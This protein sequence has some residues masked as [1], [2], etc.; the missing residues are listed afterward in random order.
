VSVVLSRVTYLLFPSE[1]EDVQRSLPSGEHVIDREVCLEESDGSK[2]YI[3]WA[4]E[5]EQYCVG[6]K[7]SSWFIPSEIVEIDMSSHILWKSLVG[8]ALDVVW[9]DDKHQVLEIRADRSPVYLSSREADRWFA[10]TISVSGA[11]PALQSDAAMERS[12]DA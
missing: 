9:H 1:A 5:P 6:V 11:R 2:R 4:Q 10:D 3:S 7:L 8:S 12:R